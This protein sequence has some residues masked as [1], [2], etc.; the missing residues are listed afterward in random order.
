[1]AADPDE[2]VNLVARPEHAQ[3]LAAL[4][5]ALSTHM[6]ANGDLGLPTENALR[7]PPPKVAPKD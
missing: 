5:A 4:R 7:P 3:E 2:Q 1:L 6:A